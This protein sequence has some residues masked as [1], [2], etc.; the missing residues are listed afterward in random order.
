MV[1][2]SKR[3]AWRK[4]NTDD[5]QEAVEEER[6][7]GAVV[8]KLRRPADTGAESRR[9]RRAEERKKSKAGAAG[10]YAD[11]AE[12]DAVEQGADEDGDDLFTVDTAGSGEG[13]SAKTRKEI[14]RAKLFPLKA[15]NIGLSASE[16]AKVARAAAAAQAR[17]PAKKAP[18][19]FDLWGQAPTAPAAFGRA[20]LTTQLKGAFSS[21]IGSIMPRKH[22][23]ARAPKTLHQKTGS[24]PAVV[25][26]HEGQSLNPELGAYEDLSCTAAARELERERE[27]EQLD[28]KIR[29][30]THELRDMAGPGGLKDVDESKKVEMYLSLKGMKA[31]AADSEP[32]Q[33]HIHHRQK[34]Q[35]QKNRHKKLM[36]Q[37]E[38]ESAELRQKRLEKSVGEVGSILKEMKEE[39]ELGENRKRYHASLQSEKRRLEE[40]EGVVG[41][42]R[43]LGR[44]VFAERALVIPDAEAAKKGL[45]AAKLK[46]SA[47][48]ERIS[49]IVRRGL[50]CAPPEGSRSE[51]VRHNKRNSRLKKGRKYISKHMR[52]K[53]SLLRK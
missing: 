30:L 49:S 23:P 45:R 10:A 6:R 5:V 37:D 13:L 44:T 1:K 21:A 50:T 47:I 9:R 20:A 46:D 28:R 35:A 17:V 31:G 25:P 41:K 8:A 3:R 38:M 18:E 36:V 43:R 52:G 27:N 39:A 53:G 19:V 24:A 29:P 33:A 34:S 16:E 48:H 22:T 26:A 42:R 15:G 2:T 51:V 11:E 4:A 14:A 7:V 12:A 40:Q 32:A